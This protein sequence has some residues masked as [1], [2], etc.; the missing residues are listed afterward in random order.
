M[1]QAK[2]AAPNTY[3]IPGIFLLYLL[4]NVVSKSI[5]R[6]EASDKI[7][8]KNIIVRPIDSKKKNIQRTSAFFA[9][10]TPVTRGLF[11]TYFDCLSISMSK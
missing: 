1:P 9:E 7:V 11:D 10:I 4:Y 2:A 8:G 3:S 6:R 5:N